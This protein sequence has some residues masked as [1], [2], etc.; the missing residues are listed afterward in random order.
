MRDLDPIAIF[1]TALGLSLDAFAVAIVSSASLDRLTRRRLF[2]LSFHFGLFQALMPVLGWAAGLPLASAVA[3]WDHWAA[4]GLLAAIGVRTMAHALRRADAEAPAGDPTR[5]LALVALSVATSIDALAVGA[6]FAFLKVRILVPVAAI[7]AVAAAMTVLGMWIGK[8]A[9]EAFG[10]SAEFLGGL[11]LLGI[12][13]K[14]LLE[15][16]LAPPAG[17]P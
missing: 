10:R 8:R 6:T 14:I 16:L 9:G 17:A 1:G 7:G 11:V 13:L 3:G 4:F 5:G 12:G 15:H 2:R